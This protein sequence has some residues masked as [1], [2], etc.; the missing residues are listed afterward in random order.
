GR[1]AIDANTG[2]ITVANSGLIDF[3]DSS[4]H[5]V[6]V[7]VTDGTHIVSEALTISVTDVNE[8]PT[9]IYFQSPTVLL[10]ENFDDGNAD[11]WNV[12]SGFGVSGNAVVSNTNDA[13]QIVRWTDPAASNWTDYSISADLQ[14]NDNDFQGLAVRVQDDANYMQFIL[15]SGSGVVRAFRVDGGTLT[16]IATSA[17][18]IPT[19]P[20]SVGLGAQQLT[21]H[22]VGNQYTVELGGAE[23]L[24]V[25]DSTYSG[26]TVGLTASAQNF[27]SSWDNIQVTSAPISINESAANG[28]VVGYAYGIDDDNADTLNYTLTDNAGG[29]FAISSAGEITVANTSLIDF[30]TLTSHAI[31]VQVDDGNGNQITENLTIGIDDDVA[32]TGI[33]ATTTSEGGLSLNT[34]G[35]NDTYLIADDGGAILGGLSSVTIEMQ[36]SST[37]TAGTHPLFSYASSTNAN[38]LEL[39]IHSGGN[40]Q[41]NL[42]PGGDSSDVGTFDYHSLFDGEQHALAFTWDNTS[43]DW[44]VFVDGVSVDSGT[45]LATGATIRGS[46]GDGEIVFGQEQSTT[47]GGFASTKVFKGNLYDVR[48]FDDVRTATEIAASYRGDLPH[49]EPGLLANWKFDQLSSGGVLLDQVSG[50]NLTANHATGTGFT[51]SDPSLTY[52]IDENAID[53]TVVGQVNAIDAARDAQIAAL[54][55]ADS[56][57]VYSAESGKFFKSYD[58]NINYAT[59]ESNALAD[60]LNGVAGQIA[61]AESATQNEILHGLASDMGRDIWLGMSDAIVEGEW[62]W[63]EA[64]VEADL[65]WVGDGDGYAVAEYTNFEANEP[66]DFNGEDQMTLLHTTGEWNDREGNQGYVVEWNADEV[67]DATQAITYSI[68]SQTISGAF[69]LDSSTGQI[70]VADG[71]LLDA[72]TQAT[73]AVTIRATDVEGNTRDDSFTISLNNLVEDNNAPT[74]LSSG[75][76]LNADGGN[77]AYLIADDGGAILGGLDSYSFEAQFSSTTENDLI[78]VSYAAGAGSGNDFLIN[79][80]ANGDLGLVMGNSGVTLSGIDYSQLMDGEIHALAVTWESTNGSYA[81]YVDGELTDSGVGLRTGNTVGGSTGTG[82][83]LFG[84]EQDSVGGGFQTTQVFEGTLY[85]VRIWNEVRSQAEIALNHHQKFDSSNL[86]SGLIANWQMDGFN[87]SDEVVDVVSGN[88]LSVGDAGDGGSWI[89]STVVEDLHI[90]ENAIDGASVG[91]VVPTDPDSP[92]DIVSD[93]LFL[94]A[95]DPTNF[96]T[97]SAGQTFGDWTVRHGD[98]DLIGTFFEESPLGGRSI[99]LNGGSASGI[100]QTLT[101][102]PG[103]QYQVVFS[104]SGNFNAGESTKDIRASAGGISQDFSVTQPPGWSTSNML[105]QARSFTFTADSTTTDLDFQSLDIAGGA[106]GPTLAE[107]H[108]IEIPHAVSTILN[109]DSA[110]SYDAATGKFYR[111]SDSNATWVNAQAGAVASTLNGVNGQLVTIRSAYEDRLVRQISLDEGRNPWLGAS[112][113]LSEGDWR[114]YDGTEAGETIWTG[115]ESGTAA[116]GQYT[117]FG[118]YDMDS[119]SDHDYARLNRHTGFWSTLNSSSNNHYLI[120]WDASEVLSNF[121]FSLTD[122]ASGRFAIDGSTGEITVADGSL[123]DFE[124]ATSH[125]VTVQTTDAAGNSY[126]E[127]LTINIDDASEALQLADGGTSFTDTQAQEVAVT[128]GSGNDTIVGTDGDDVLQGD[129]THVK[130]VAYQNFNA[131]GT[132][133]EILF[134][135]VNE[136]GAT[137]VNEISL[138]DSLGG[139]FHEHI[140]VTQLTNGSFVVAWDDVSGATEQTRFQIIDPDGNL[141]LG[142]PPSVQG[143][144]HTLAD[145]ILGDY[146]EP[147]I[148]GLTDGGFVI[149]WDQGSGTSGDIFVQ[150]YDALGVAVG[151]ATAVHATSGIVHREPAIH[152]LDD[153][154][155]VVVWN[156]DAPG[157][158]SWNSEPLQDLYMRVF[159]T[160]GT[161]PTATGAAVQVDTVVGTGN[162]SGYQE[163]ATIEVL[164]NGNIVIGWQAHHNDNVSDES[165]YN[166]YIRVMQEDGTPVSSSIQVNPTAIPQDTLSIT[167]L[168][169][170]NFVVAYKSSNNSG[171][172]WRDEVRAQVYDSSGNEVG[173]E[174]LVSEASLITNHGPSVTSLADGGFQVVWHIDEGGDEDGTAVLLKSFDSSGNEQHSAPLR[175]NETT[176]NDQKFAQVSSSTG[177]VGGGDDNLTGGAGDD[178]IDGHDGTDTAHFSGNLADYSIAYNAAKDQ[179]TVTDLRS[180]SPDG[181]D[182]VSNVE[183]FAFVD[184]TVLSS[185]FVISPSNTVPAAQSIDENTTLTFSSGNGNAVSVSDGHIGLNSVLQV[186]LTASPSGTLTLSQT[187]GLTFV[188]GSNGANSF[189]FNGSESD[190]NAALEGLTYTPNTN[191]DGSVTLELSTSLAGDLVGHYQFEGNADD[192]SAGT[193]ENGTLIGDA[194]LVNDP[195]RGD[196]LS[197]DGVSDG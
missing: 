59:A 187:T 30:E 136:Y 174:I 56:D 6:T 145:A 21:V 134:K 85:D 192:T 73:H 100:Y 32:P 20:D 71:T 181:T 184:G 82:E 104:M 72:D 158:P 173:A 159:D 12:P 131:A 196:V 55:A 42:A 99:D 57:L 135:L 28:T 155:F 189:V 64:G 1:F 69:A 101:T 95:P 142:T 37:D 92:Q 61:T 43:G 129:S 165:F 24:S 171:G 29:R 3:E 2:V 96:A 121:T 102:E 27:G 77:D 87:G 106:N 31:T 94:E 193:G 156:Q 168:D 126:S 167:S 39:M 11:G 90:S 78:L 79:L 103:R 172:P 120:E 45:G 51:N 140:A 182:K 107:I 49:D 175:I 70:T 166:G 9:G 86:P 191:F 163:N 54:L 154:K 162:S 68:Q 122:D 108:V 53:G 5:N 97:Y 151:S 63:R 130:L 23:V 186:S 115:N 180:G 170:G 75:I 109:N 111:M 13:D 15:N 157:A 44:E 66:N 143:S 179:F 25:T 48:I 14:L 124:S 76:E 137:L 185:D 153:G 139:T 127:S 188:E 81:V 128:G 152:A 93:G 35:G 19:T 47:G 195:Q 98:V 178:F 116:A 176:A 105:W 197:L 18:V 110:L 60:F 41:M 91:F 67:L 65:V 26:G 149:A 119:T 50:N 62:R 112:D 125:S 169:D 74:D 34:D 147:A 84:Q 114:W 40:L 177:L 144:A 183:Q 150:R 38:S 113:V 88:N 80:G 4:S 161:T 52:S 46:A 141:T 83:L 148:T 10:E 117:N 160:S 118:Y 133:S 138:S 36:F 89:T 16:E 17:V 58:V 194:T 132:E 22:A 146:G 8:A 164:S 7:Q 190:I 33:E 123:I